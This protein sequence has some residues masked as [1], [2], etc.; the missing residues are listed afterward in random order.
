MSKR[1]TAYSYIRFSSPEQAKGD[2]F[3]R[4]SERRD[5]FLRRNNL[6]LDDSLRLVD[7]GISG[8][9]GL[10]RSNP[11]RYALAKFIQMAGQGKIP[12]GSFLIVE[13]L[14]RLSREDIRPALSLFLQILDYGINI[15]QL[16]P[17]TVYRHEKTDEMQLFQAIMELR[18]G[19][20]ESAMKSMRVG[21][22]WS[23]KRKRADKEKLTAH[24]PYWLRLVDGRFEEIAERV[25]IVRRIFR[26][27]IDGS[28]HGTIAKALNEEGVEP[29]RGGNCWH[30]SYVAKIL[31]NRAVVGEYQPHTVAKKTKRKAIGEPVPNYYPAVVAENV[32]YAARDA[33]QNRRTASGPNQQQ[34]RN[35]FSG[36]MHDCRDDCPVFFNGDLL[37]SYKGKF[38]GGTFVSFPYAPFEE[39]VLKTLR[40]VEAADL[41]EGKTQPDRVP[42]L[43]S[44]LAECE[45][46]L[47]KLQGALEGDGDLPTLLR[48]VRSVEAKKGAIQ[49]EL[50]TARQESRSNVSESLAE[51]K[52]LASAPRPKLKAIIRRI[53]EEIRVVFFKSG[54]DSYAACQ[55]FFKGEG[56]RTLL[57]HHRRATTGIQSTP[58][59]LECVAS[60]AS[61]AGQIDLR[62]K[63]DL[64]YI[65][66]WLAVLYPSEASIARQIAASPLTPKER[67][68]VW[69]E[70]TG[71]SVGDF[72]RK[73]RG[74]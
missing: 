29:W 62:T 3:R 55:V 37:V 50:E 26:M 49:E 34:A 16:E 10:H 70:R 7:D 60:C 9:V 25:A 23:Q 59:V 35:L 71:K 47:R 32:F 31:N 13:N 39:A 30:P 33:R 42:V 54:G 19:N 63:P 17:E 12:R 56:C 43:E 74:C 68:K 11:D 4:Q 38:G 15:V 69:F 8:F 57:I 6:R 44:Q 65:A 14:D 40:E 48:A 5:E 22:A 53:I 28:G 18:R 72:Y 1:P 41:V 66:S 51:F 24:C 64:D 36:L 46:K 27:A 58:A 52:G 45:E 67:L 73:A 2:S 61:E 20:S 21:E